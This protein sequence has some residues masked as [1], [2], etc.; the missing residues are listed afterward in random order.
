M[1]PEIGECEADGKETGRRMGN[2]MFGADLK[3]IRFSSGVSKS[4][5]FDNCLDHYFD[6]LWFEFFLLVM[7]QNNNI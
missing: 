2:M 7:F 6:F 5:T 1:P 4:V 3:Q